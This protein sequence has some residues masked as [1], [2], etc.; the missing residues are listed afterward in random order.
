MENTPEISYNSPLMEV[1]SDIG[2]PDTQPT[3]E[4]TYRDSTPPL[5]PLPLT[6]PSLTPPL[7]PPLAP[8]ALLQKRH[9]TYYFE[10]LH[11]KVCSIVQSE[12]YNLG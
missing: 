4:S 2:L 5:A 1:K 10:M 12:T 8:E 9:N 7:P 6:P 11:L 3:S